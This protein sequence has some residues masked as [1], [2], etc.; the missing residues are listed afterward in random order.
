MSLSSEEILRGLGDYSIDVGITYLD[1]EPIDDLLAT[2]LY[3]ER[4]CLFVPEGHT[5]AERAHRSRGEKP[6]SCRSDF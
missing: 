4:Y 5:M 6:P 1:N 2:P 3:I